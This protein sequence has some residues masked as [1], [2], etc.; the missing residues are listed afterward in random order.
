MKDLKKQLKRMKKDAT[1]SREFK[2]VLWSALSDAYDKKYSR[3]H[4]HSPLFRFAAVGMVAIVLFVSTGAGVYAYESPDVVEGHPLHFVKQG[5][6]RVEGQFAFTPEQRA[7]FHAKMMERRIEEA[8]HHQQNIQF[9][10]M[11]APKI[12]DELG[13][14]QDELRERVK[15]PELRD[16]LMKDLTEKNKRYAEVLARVIESEEGM[17]EDMLPP[18]PLPP[19]LHE[20]VLSIIEEVREQDLSPRER[21]EYVR[22]RLMPILNEFRLQRMEYVQ[23]LHTEEAEDSF[24]SEVEIQGTVEQPQSTKFGF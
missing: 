20:E 12:A 16:Q 22:E 6:E 19:E 5:I 8:E 2:S 15:D 7:R 18:L 14:T 23:P 13:L 1:P 9:L 17:R 21:R 10:R 11:V 4:A 24:R 3:R